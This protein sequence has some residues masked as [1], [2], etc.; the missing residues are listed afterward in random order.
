MA[1]AG[2]SVDRP[3]TA[4]EVLLAAGIQYA[5]CGAAYT[6]NYIPVGLIADRAPSV[7]ILIW[8][9]KLSDSLS[10]S[11]PYSVMLRTETDIP[12][13]T[14]QVSIAARDPKDFTQSTTRKLG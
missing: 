6:A 4:T 8:I 7:A 1:A 12:R 11:V 5:Q 3:S 9:D 14:V 10:L 2:S 13:E